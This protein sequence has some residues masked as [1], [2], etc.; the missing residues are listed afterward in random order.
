MSGIAVPRASGPAGN[1]RNLTWSARFSTSTPGVTVHWAWGKASYKKFSDDYNAL[2][3]AVADIV[4]EKGKHRTVDEA[5]TPVAFK[6]D[7]VD[8]D[9][10]DDSATM[11][12][13]TSPTTSASA[14]IP[15]SLPQVTTTCTGGG[16]APR[17]R[18]PSRRARRD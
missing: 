7:V 16:Q 13:T 14:A 9:D 2:G 10:D 4:T 17:A 18:G 8:D 11:T 6:A 5:G 3:L 1:A 12:T 15:S